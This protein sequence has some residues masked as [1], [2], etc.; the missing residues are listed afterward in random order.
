[1]MASQ[2]I[3]NDR[4]PS[5]LIADDDVLIL[6]L[7]S[8]GFEIH[9]CRV[10]KAENG[11]DAWAVFNR[12]PIDLVLTDIRMPGLDGAQLSHRIRKRSPMVKIAVMTGGDA[13]AATDLLK[14]GTA[15]YYFQK[16]F[17]LIGVCSSLVP[18]AKSVCS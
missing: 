5:V 13:D 1:M 3:R 9:G 8:E 18:A 4:V 17:N 15:D 14:A 10:F 16:P 7:L 11:V 2:P 6:E 12:E